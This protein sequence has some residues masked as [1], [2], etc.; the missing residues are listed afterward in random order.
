MKYVF[1]AITISGLAV[2]LYA[3]IAPRIANPDMSEM[4]LFLTYWK[5][6]AVCTVLG[7]AL[8]Y[9]GI[10]AEAVAQHVQERNK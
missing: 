10:I 8:A 1:R 9:G 4:R 5:L 7:P 3:A 2:I 6:Y